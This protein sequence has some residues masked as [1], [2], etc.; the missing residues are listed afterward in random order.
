MFKA[1]EL[2]A[3]QLIKPDDGSGLWLYR[4]GWHDDRVA[5]MVSPTLGA[6][7][8]AKLRVEMFGE[9]RPTTKR[10]EEKVQEL[11][12]LCVRLTARLADMEARYN[13]LCDN[14]AVNRVMDVK[15]L[16][17]PVAKVEGSKG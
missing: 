2:L 10:R 5:K 15:H 14:L 4:D 7:H 16:K 3:Q 17:V 12:D 11:T 6:H 1:H 13:R 9:L 8:V